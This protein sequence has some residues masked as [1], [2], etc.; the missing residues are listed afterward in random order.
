MKRVLN[1][2]SIAYECQT[3]LQ[4]SPLIINGNFYY[5]VYCNLSRNPI[6]YIN[7]HAQLFT[8]SK[9]VIFVRSLYLFQYFVY[10]SNG[11]SG[12]TVRLP[13]AG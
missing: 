12:E 10:A 3:V 4:E 9:S 6:L 7:V 8:A 5:M 2:A 1:F 11:D 13:C